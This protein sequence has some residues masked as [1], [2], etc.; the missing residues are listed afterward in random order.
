M[1]SSVD[2]LLPA[3]RRPF[4]DLQASGALIDAVVFMDDGA[5]DTIRWLGGV[6]FLASLGGVAAVSLD[7]EAAAADPAALDL[8]SMRAEA[9]VRA[10]VFLVGS[11]W[12]AESALDRLVSNAHYQLVTVCCSM[13]E[14]A[15]SYHPLAAALPPFSYAAY[16]AELTARMR[17]RQTTAE[18]AAEVADADL[19]VGAPRKKMQWQ[20]TAVAQYF[21]LH[22]MPLREGAAGAAAAFT[23]APPSDRVFPLTLGS[24]TT[25]G[26]ARMG[27]IADVMVDDLAAASK[28]ELSLL[29]FALGGAMRTLGLDVSDHVYSLGDTALLVGNKTL[30]L[31]K[32]IERDALSGAANDPYAPP[33]SKGALVIVDRTLDLVAPT[34]A[35]RGGGG[36]GGDGER[37]RGGGFAP[38]ALDVAIARAAPARPGSSLAPP[39]A[40]VDAL[41]REL[42]RCDAARRWCPTTSRGGTRT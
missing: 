21:A 2:A 36:G 30:S 3:C 32:A 13:R 31:L 17:G 16:A 10:V 23:L 38:S 14:A 34:V 35:R 29:A 19:A 6:P 7:T 9:P 24:L 28:S 4:F 40:S 33:R 26:R 39:R 5:A 15:F 12:D 8:R 27:H 41:E 1:K 18:A 25:A 37:E 11:V 22:V 42:R 20:P